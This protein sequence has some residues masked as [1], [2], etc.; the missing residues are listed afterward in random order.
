MGKERLETDGRNRYRCSKLLSTINAKTRKR[1]GHMMGGSIDY[2]HLLQISYGGFL[3][4]SR[5][6]L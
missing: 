5:L 2:R 3:V 1:K 4:I 6:I